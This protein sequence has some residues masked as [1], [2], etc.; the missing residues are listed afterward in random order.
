MPNALELE[1]IS[2]EDSNSPTTK[3]SAQAVLSNQG[4]LLD[5]GMFSDVTIIVKGVE[6]RAHK[7]ILSG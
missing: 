3:S 1:T 2:S 6:I 5:S 4:N 7:N